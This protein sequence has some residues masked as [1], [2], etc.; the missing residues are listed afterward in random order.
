MAEHI[1]HAT[2][3][4]DEIPIDQ[5]RHD[6]NKYKSLDRIPA[7]SVGHLQI[8]AEGPEHHTNGCPGKAIF[9]QQF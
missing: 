1:K 3:M 9:I 8:K 2:E 5:Q 4:I 7:R 6:D